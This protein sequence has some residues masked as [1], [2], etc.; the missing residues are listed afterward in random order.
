MTK[1]RNRKGT[2][3]DV[4]QRYSRNRSEI[5]MFGLLVRTILTICGRQ[6]TSS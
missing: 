1:I 6:H 5:F 2:V 4:L 3:T